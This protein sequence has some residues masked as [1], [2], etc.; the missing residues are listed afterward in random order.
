MGG[1]YYYIQKV[2]RNQTS[3]QGHEIG[4]LHYK[5]RSSTG[6]ECPDATPA[7][8]WW[9]S[10]PDRQVFASDRRGGNIASMQGKYIK[11]IPSAVSLF[12]QKLEA[13]NVFDLL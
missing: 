13:K 8:F 5:R 3:G 11:I 10:A 6:G 4:G 7:I 1:H 2:P 12:Y 9:V